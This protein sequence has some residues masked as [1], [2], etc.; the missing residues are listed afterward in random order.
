MVK[1][2]NDGFDPTGSVERLGADPA[3]AARPKRGGPPAAAD[4]LHISD[5][6]SRLAALETRFAATGVFDAARVEAIA[7]AMRE[8]RFTVNPEAVADKLLDSVRELLRK[9]P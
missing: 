8:G 4:T 2:T 3:G 9:A 1:I 7:A 5:L 6:S